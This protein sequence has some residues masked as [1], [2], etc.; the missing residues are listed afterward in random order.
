MSPL[1]SVVLCTYNAE[2]H[3][4]ECIQSLLNQTFTDFEII[5]VD[6][7]STDRTTLYLDAIH[8]PRIR[9]YK[10][11][12]NYGIIYA[13]TKGF[14]LAKGRYIAI[15]DADDVAHPERLQLQYDYLE[16]NNIDICGSWHQ[17][18]YNDTGKVRSRGG[19]ITNSDIKALLAIYCP[20]SNPSVS[21]KSEIIKFY[22]YDP[23]N[24]YAE[25][26]G[27]WCDIAASGGNFYNIPRHLVTYRIHPSQISQQKKKDA[28]KAFE[29][30]RASYISKLL[31]MALIP[32]S[33]PYHMR[34]KEGLKFMKILNEKIT[35]ISFSANYQLYA[36]FQYRANGLL[37]PVIR[38]E[39]LVVAL[40][41]TLHGRC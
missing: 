10:L 19:P 37:T 13:R 20:I 11:G 15:M 29:L 4:H 28:Q 8:D 22:R 21:G 40:W 38:L 41:A 24:E 26:Y 39:R 7:G 32:K 30:I 27:M 18:L 2:A 3:L 33:M 14:S 12:S 16:N 9:L 17:S 23:N 34:L 31:G 35:Q 6:D 25:D 1:F 5:I 36:E